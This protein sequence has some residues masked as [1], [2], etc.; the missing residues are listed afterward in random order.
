MKKIY[1]YSIVLIIFCACKNQVNEK[2]SMQKFCTSDSTL[3]CQIPTFMV[4]TK[5]ESNS[6]L[7]S[8]NNKIVNIM[9][10]E[11]PNELNLEKYAQQLTENNRS[12]LTLV[13]YND[14][15]IS[16]E[17]QKG[18]VTMPA[19]IFSLHKCNGYSIVVTT[20]GLNLNVHNSISHSIM[21]KKPKMKLYK[22]RYIDINYPS[23]WIL[24]EHPNLPATDVYIG[25]NNRTFGVGVFRL[26]N[27]EG[28][29]FN[30]IMS[31]LRDSFREYAN[32]NLSYEQI[33]GIRWCKHDI[34]MVVG[35]MK[36]RQIAYYCMKGDYIYNV[37]FTN[38]GD[39]DISGNLNIIKSMMETITLK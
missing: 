34:S 38:V 19:L 35:E 33:N 5:E 1:L 11:L 25:R 17:I 37:K 23:D 9:M 28:I 13:E 15:L 32:V 8:G 10:T 29:P 22:G 6:L 24:D 14:S 7:F 2:I 39:I 12:D 20:M 16:Y 26:K 3:C 27:E 36:N 30:E 21:C 18:I 31:N 4:L